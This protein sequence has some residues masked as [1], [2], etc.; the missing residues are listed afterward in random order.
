MTGSGEPQSSHIIRL[1]GPWALCSGGQGR[2]DVNSSRE[3]RVSLTEDWLSRVRD[4]DAP[5]VTL[6]R[7]FHR[8]TGLLKDPR[9]ALCIELP[10]NVQGDVLLNNMRL[11]I[12]QSSGARFEIGHVL[13]ERNDLSIEIVT[14]SEDSSQ[15]HTE[16]L[17]RFASRVWLEIME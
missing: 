15:A 7:F 9:V 17:V 3:L 5:A 11:G 2:K 10:P 4:F 16:S 14:Q 13:Q 12:L 8:P 6:R 1:R